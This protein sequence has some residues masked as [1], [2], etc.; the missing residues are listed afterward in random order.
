MMNKIKNILQRDVAL[1]RLLY[2]RITSGVG[3]ASTE[4]VAGRCSVTHG[5]PQNYRILN[6]FVSCFGVVSFFLIKTVL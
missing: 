6:F 3:K 2:Y 5:D 4:N 1:M